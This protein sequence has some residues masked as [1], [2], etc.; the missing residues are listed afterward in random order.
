MATPSSSYH[1][2]TDGTVTISLARR[3]LE[4]G[5]YAVP[6]G[7]DDPD[8]KSWLIPQS[9]IPLHEPMAGPSDPP[10]ETVIKA[11]EEFPG[12]GIS[13]AAPYLR[14]PNNNDMFVI[15]VDIDD[16]T[17][18]DTIAIIIDKP[19]P[20]RKGSRGVGFYLRYPA[21][22]TIPT[23][24]RD[25]NQPIPG[26]AK[27]TKMRVMEFAHKGADSYIDFMGLKHAHM[28][29]PP[30]L[31]MKATRAAQRNIY[32][33]WLEFPGSDKTLRIEDIAPKRPYHHNALP[34]APYLSICKEPYVHPV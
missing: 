21:M 24:L 9:G 10:L 30:T 20:I 28:L 3:L 18:I 1:Q 29:I 27:D 4:L 12:C 31:S 19:C 13:I 33:Q 26:W 14:S 11:F 7:G 34:Y 8:A 32:Y 25:R 16:Q 15:D 17:L 5:Y 6:V 22:T 2:L 23:L